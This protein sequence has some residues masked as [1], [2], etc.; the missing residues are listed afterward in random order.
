MANE[1]KWTYGTQVTL[2]ANGGQATTGAFAAANDASLSSTNHSNYPYADFV[3]TCDFGAAVGAGV[4]VN[5]YRQDLAI[6]GATNAP[7][8]ATT[9]KYFFCGAFVIPSGQSA[10]ATYPLPNVP[11]TS[12][13]QFSIENGTA[14]NLSAGWVLKAT[15]KTYVPGS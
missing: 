2:E 8:P 10:S 7:A 6:D 1:L 13:C 15:P 4:T 12:Q 9:Y 14:Q 5:L 11:L 3:L